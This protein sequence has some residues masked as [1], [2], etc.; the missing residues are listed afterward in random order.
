M[1][2]RELGGL[3]L[4]PLSLLSH[5]LYDSP[6]TTFLAYPVLNKLSEA[7][8]VVLQGVGE[9]FG[10]ECP[11]PFPTGTYHRGIHLYP[12]TIH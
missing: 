6:S 2:V 9:G 5:S 1:I 4:Y 3:F 11:S 8:S 12:K 7:L 10:G